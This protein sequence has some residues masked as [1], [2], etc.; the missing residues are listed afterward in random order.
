MLALQGK[1]AVVSGA[2]G[3]MGQAAAR[4]RVGQGCRVALGRFHED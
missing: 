1:V 3:T 4:A 2:T